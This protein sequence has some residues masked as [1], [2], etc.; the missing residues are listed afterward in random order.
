MKS[1]STKNF[2][3]ILSYSVCAY[4]I[5][6][7]ISYI[8]ILTK[9]DLHFLGYTE[10]I[11]RP[12]YKNLFIKKSSHDPL[13]LRLAQ[14]FLLEII[15]DI[16]LYT[17][18]H[19]N[20]IILDLFL[21]DRILH[22]PLLEI[23]LTDTLLFRKQ[24]SIDIVRTILIYLTM[25][26]NRI[27]KCFENVFQRFLTLWSQESFIRFSSNTQHF[28]ICQC[29][30]IC[31]SLNKQLKLNEDKDKII[32]SVLNGIRIHIE[33]T[34]DYIRRRGQFIG[35]LIIQRI[36]LFSPSNQLHF[37]TYDK[38]HSEIQI[39]TKLA[40]L[41]HSLNDR[42]LSDDDDD[43]KEKIRMKKGQSTITEYLNL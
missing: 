8:S 1:E 28:Y 6:K 10:Y 36:N 35:E 18:Q 37:D 16:L 5:K 39:L 43:E 23:Y 38:N 33:S 17:I 22:L 9:H 41:N 31:L 21:S 4:S 26:T 29:I 30:C 11:W 19:G 42:E 24:L 3:T 20:A 34:F 27:E 15:D 2:T 14:Y 40:E 32:M 25:S 13:W 12:L 7:E